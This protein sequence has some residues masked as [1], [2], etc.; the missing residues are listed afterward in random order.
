MAHAHPL[1][2]P[3]P[4]RTDSREARQ[5]SFPRLPLFGALAL[6][7]F[8]VAATIFG[9]VTEIGTLRVDRGSPLAV[10][11]ITILDGVNDTVVVRDAVT[12]E[13]LGEYGP[14]EGGFVR[15]SLR[16]LKRFRLVEEASHDAPWRLM[17][18]QSGAVS[19]SDTVTGQRIYLNAFGP[20]QVAAFETFLEDETTTG[21]KTP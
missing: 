14:T 17:R 7:G 19:I 13:V 2:Q 9:Q 8:A 21:R 11:D 15:G 5:A 12:G 10:R 1:A 6:I 3:L 4:S 18:W 16:G 20:D